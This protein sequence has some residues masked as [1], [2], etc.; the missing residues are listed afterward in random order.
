MPRDARVGINGT[1]SF[2]C[3]TTGSPP[4]TTYWTHE[5]SGHVVG[6]G[7]T[8]GGGRWAVDSNN[9]LTVK[10]ARVGDEGYYVCSAVGVAGAALARAHLEVQSL[11]DIPPPLIALGAMNQTLPLG[12][13]GEL[14]CEARGTP[15]P[16]VVWYRGDTVIHPD[17]RTSITPLGTLRLTGL[18]ITHFSITHSTLL[19]C[20]LCCLDCF[21]SSLS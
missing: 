13:E 19:S 6:A 16:Q 7:Q 4:P 12:T 18:S 17:H 2:E 1:A 20:P 8:W 5:G 11:D 10:G 14:P 3:R 21:L 15:E 9:T